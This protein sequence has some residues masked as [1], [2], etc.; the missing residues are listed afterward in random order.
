MESL[1]HDIFLKIEGVPIHLGTAIDW[2]GNDK[3]YSYAGIYVPIHLGTAI[4]WKV[5]DNTIRHIDKKGSY[6]LR[7]GDRLESGI[8]VNNSQTRTEFLFT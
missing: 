4:D 1:A 2:K 7:D 3:L 6:S 8:L 5:W